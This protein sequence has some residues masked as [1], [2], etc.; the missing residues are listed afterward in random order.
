M[1]S[2]I[3]GRRE[4]VGAFLSLSCAR[5]APEVR[6][7]RTSLILATSR[8]RI[9][10]PIFV[11]IE[12]GFF[13]QQGLDVE[14]EL[15]DTAQPMAD[16]LAAGRVS[17]GGYVALPILFDPARPRMKVRVL[18]A[19]VE[20]ASHRL[21][22]LLVRKASKLTA[23]D[24]LRG[25]RIGILPTLAYRRWLEAVLEH[26]GVPLDAVRIVPVAPAHQVQSLEGGGIDALFTGDPMATA[27]LSRGVARLLSAS[28]E[29]PRALGDPFIFGTFAVSEELV[30]EHPGTVRALDAGLDAA[31]AVIDRDPSHALESMLPYVRGPERPF[32]R[33]YPK[34]RYVRTRELDPGQLDRALALA[35]TT[36]T[37]K[38]VVVP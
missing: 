33:Q 30:T 5:R 24:D 15:F 21:S 19:V 29:V 13:K 11:A 7:A 10:L 32:V 8:L 26:E 35:G 37:A 25:H 20:D 27:A 9:S 22:Y 16:E 2:R 34:A 6:E 28:P 14:L 1:G 4:A 18:T 17:A 23:W 38:D 31:I 36:Q 12:R 3:L